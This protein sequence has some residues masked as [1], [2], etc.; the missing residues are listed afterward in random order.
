MGHYPDPAPPPADLPA[1]EEGT[2]FS[3]QLWQYRTHRGWT[4]EELAE[5]AGLS[6]RGIRALEQ[7]E[8]HRPYKHTIRLLADAL[9]LTGE[10][11]ALFES[12]A[13]DR[14]LGAE[15]PGPDLSPAIPSAGQ[16]ARPVGGRSTLVQKPTSAEH[17][18]VLGSTAEVMTLPP[19]GQSSAPGMP[20]ERKLVTVLFADVT[21][22]TALGE[23]L[24]PEDVRALMSR[25]YDHARQ[26]VSDHGGTLEKFIGGAVMAVFG[27]P[28][29][30][31]DDAE[32]AVAAALALQQAVAE[33]PELADVSLRIGITTGE[34]VATSDPAATDFLVTGDAVNV[35]AR[36][37]QCA[38]PGEILATERTYAAAGAVFI[39]AEGREVEVKGKREPLRVFPL[40][41]A[42]EVR[43]VA[44]PRLVGREDDL[45]MLSLLQ[46]R[47]LREGRPQLV[48][49]VAPAG[50]GK[51]RLLEEFLGSLESASVRTATS[52][53]LP[54]GQTL[55][56]WPLRGLMEELLGGI[57]RQ[58][59]VKTFREAGHMPEDAARL[60]DL[61]LATLGIEGETLTERESVFAA[62]RLLSE[63]LARQGPLI[64][65]FE[66]LHWA[67]DSLL[68]LVERIMQPRT[69][70]PLLLI[71]VSRPEL[72]DRRPA[73]GAGV[74][75]N[76][77]TL[78]LQP[79]G[80]EQTAELVAQ[81]GPDLP[82]AL[83]RKIVERS[84]GNPFF[85][86]ELVRGLA[87]RGI[88]VE[89]QGM[90]AVP[91]TV[92]AA[93]LAR[94]DLLE[95]TERRVLQAAAVGGRLFRPAIVQA[96]LGNLGSRDL[97]AA[98]DDLLA[99]DLIIP[100]E[101]G[102][103]A[104]RHILIRDVAY[105]TLARAER[106]RMHLG[107]AIWL[108]DFAQDR[109]DEYVELIAYHYREALLLG[110][111]SGGFRAVTVD[112]ARAVAALEQAGEIAGRAGAGAEAHRYLE[113]AIAV[114]DEDD[115]GRL[116]EKLGDALV[117]GDDAIAA[118]RKALE[119]WRQ[120]GASN[121]GMGA[122]LLRKILTVYLR[123]FGTVGATTLTLAALTEMRDEARRLA[124]EAG[125]EDR[126]RFRLV[127]VF[128]PIRRRYA[129][130][131]STSVSREEMEEHRATA[132]A[133]A[134]YFEER[135]EWETFSAMLDG[136]IANS[137]YMERWDDMIAA[138][139]RRLAA[140]QLP[141]RERGDALHMIALASWAKG[142]YDVALDVVQEAIASIR[143]GDPI[144]HL[145]EL[146]RDG[147]NAS[148]WAGRWSDLA[149][150][151]SVA[152]LL[153]QQLED[154]RPS[155]L[156]WVYL[157]WLTVAI[158]RDDRATADACIALLRRLTQQAEAG[159]A[160]LGTVAEALRA[161]DMSQL[162]LDP[163]ASFFAWFWTL[164]MLNERGIPAPDALIDYVLDHT[165]EYKPVGPSHLAVAKAIR[166][167]DPAQLAA[168]ID[169]VEAHGRVPDTARL[170]IV[171]AEMTGDPAP[172]DQAR[173]VLERLGDRQFLR[174]L[175]EVAA[176]LR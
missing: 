121:P 141:A 1:I 37:Q 148:Y 52:R 55:T 76:F 119:R 157:L 50:T 156:I 84:G 140:P 147:A 86:T 39:F 126:W 125:E 131:E 94:L 31:G 41:G 93:V 164:W 118:Y 74:R 154:E 6:P 68:D 60:S 136:Y 97:D 53:C 20:E 46:R 24:D 70:A 166:D 56:F 104:F 32:R 120:A 29:V 25:Y 168:E 105:G 143:P 129:V 116:Y 127:D 117:Y 73:W 135:G 173:P 22:S 15:P 65:V 106:A 130:G 64:V 144:T 80:A 122:R 71:A 69:S 91:D 132:L 54:Y 28:Q 21:G 113:S 123:W 95:P 133:A 2:P 66:D 67:S 36:L 81:L 96:V 47:T 78:V 44:R 26:V 100:D 158:A 160:A 30:H 137:M 87:E 8:R 35:A 145:E 45:M 149:G 115:R 85:V 92:H 162:H 83:R 38:A 146:L 42:R 151:M 170:R 75:Q 58:E 27:L 165:D 7:G 11:R 153:R 43:Q 163:K 110:R 23:D 150:L 17:Q 124:E 134:A 102:A 99:R 89:D 167:R 9:G 19:G 152:D 174:R 79:L 62:W 3:V 138:A 176:S 107:V 14:S 155:A 171:L 175:E 108:E 5:R 51:T 48:S 112:V 142:D 77:T 98:I 82:E 111:R 49:I 169:A 57:D 109:Y 12:A 59:V 16:A 63:A 139:R 34:V 4:Q 13:R 128:W 88:R 161:D 33:D 114:A 103:F 101:A 72:L 159:F 172:L 40:V 61:V 10:E 18:N 90:D